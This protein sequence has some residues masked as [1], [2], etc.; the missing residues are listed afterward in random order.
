MF[1][2]K[3]DCAFAHRTL[4]RLTTKYREAVEP[5]DIALA[6]GAYF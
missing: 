3:L 4:I 5:Q 6:L 1:G 2:P